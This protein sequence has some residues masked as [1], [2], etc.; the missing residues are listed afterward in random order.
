MC[1]IIFQ[2]IFAIVGMAQSLAITHKK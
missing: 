2:L 1:L